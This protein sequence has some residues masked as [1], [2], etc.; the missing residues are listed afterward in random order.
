MKFYKLNTGVKQYKGIYG[1]N[2]LSYEITSG[3]DSRF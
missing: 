1:L 3:L 2:Q